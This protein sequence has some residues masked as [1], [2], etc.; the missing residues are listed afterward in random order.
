M[1][2]SVNVKATHLWTAE[3]S[4]KSRW[5]FIFTTCLYSYYL[6][7]LTTLC[8]WP[9]HSVHRKIRK[10]ILRYH[11]YWLNKSPKYIFNR[12]GPHLSSGIANTEE[13]DVTKF[14]PLHLLRRALSSLIWYKTVRELLKY[15]WYLSFQNAKWKGSQTDVV[16]GKLRERG[17]LHWDL[18]EIVP[19]QLIQ[20]ITNVYNRITTYYHKTSIIYNLQNSS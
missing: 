6:L 3:P 20:V 15:W 12:I 16:L 10:N 14:W 4:T 8:L 18:W 19:P 11:L 17:W 7:F 2:R 9:H 5:W 13:D 1:N